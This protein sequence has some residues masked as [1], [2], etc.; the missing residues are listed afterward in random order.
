[1]GLYTGM[2]LLFGGFLLHGGI[3]TG[4][5]TPGL[6]IGDVL[7][8]GISNGYGVAILVGSTGGGF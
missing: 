4:L 7:C 8:G 2:G 3:V 1:M 6:L 5:Y